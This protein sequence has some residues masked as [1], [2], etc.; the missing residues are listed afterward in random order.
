MNRSLLPNR[1]NSELV[2]FQHEGIA[3]RASV[4]RFADGRL[5]EVFLDGGKP[6]TGV[7]IVGA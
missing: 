3:Y 5:G 6:D 2:S 1:R 4:S 7:A